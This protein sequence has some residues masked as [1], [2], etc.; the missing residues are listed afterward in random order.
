[1]KFIS[2]IMIAFLLLF[3]A[4]NSNGNKS[5]LE[6]S[7]TIETTDVVLSSKVAG[8]V[9]ELKA[10]EGESVVKGDTLLII[11]HDNYLIQKV[12]AQAAFDAANS[13]YQL[14]KNG[15]RKEDLAQ[16][17][18]ALSQAKAN[19]KLVANDYER[20]KKLYDQ[21]AIT[22][23]QFDEISTRLVI[24]K[25]QLKQAEENLT[26]LKNF[27]RPEELSAARAKTNQAEAALNLINKTISDCFVTSPISG[28]ITN[29]YIEEGEMAVP[30]TSLFQISDIDKAEIYVYVP[31]AELAKVQ[32]GE[33]AEIRI[34]TYPDKVYE[35]KVTYISSEAEFTP[36]TIQTKDERTKLVFAVK[37][38]APNKNHEL[39]PG[40]PADVKIFLDK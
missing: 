9:T 14:L 2:K 11:D 22:K 20:F 33:K 36:K 29:K 25:S 3:T 34:D 26:K 23:K 13:S 31:E 8:E 4:C 35:G 12:Q 15:A 1:M 39:K 10:D 18:E 30:Q 6:L 16:A 24:S 32:L 19:N 28:V 27:A 5:S 17:K 38:E 21:K 37:V 40:L 7:G